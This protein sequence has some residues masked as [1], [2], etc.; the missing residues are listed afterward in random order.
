MRFLRVLLAIALVPLAA[1]G[2]GTSETPGAQSSG[3]NGFP[4]TV[5]HKYGDTTIA[6]APARVV[7]LG[8]SDHDPVLALGVKPVGAIDWF[9]ERPYGKWPWRNHFGAAPH[10]RS[11]ASGTLCSS[12]T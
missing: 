10:P 3:Q 8:L 11:S 7:T 1:C 12:R 9:G 6:K 4:V 2:G 5:T